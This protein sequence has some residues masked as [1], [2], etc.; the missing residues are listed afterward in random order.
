MSKV[1]TVEVDLALVLGHTHMP[2]H[3]LL[4][5]GRGAVIELDGNENGPFMLFANNHP[6][7]DAEV[8]VDGDRIRASVLNMRGRDPELTRD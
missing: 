1:E 5:M 8:L 3:Q 7:A 2:V 4:R 6:I